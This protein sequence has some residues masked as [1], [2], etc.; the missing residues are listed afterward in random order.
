MFGSVGRSSRPRHGGF[1]LIELMITVAVIS[2]L[3]AVAYPSYR[4]SVAKGKRAQ[5]VASL[6][7]G[8]QWMERFYA[9][10]YRYDQ[11]TAAVAVTD[12]SLFRSRFTQAPP[13]P[14]AAAYTVAID[15]AT[16]TQTAFTIVAT[17]T[18]SMAGD[19]CGDFTI[20]QLGVKSVKNYGSNFA[21]VNAALAY[22]WK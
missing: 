4:E 8:S 14:D 18:G 12:N 10:N 20:N 22:C 15:T 17:R 6:Q 7:S 16:L 11:N 19:K 3:A 13:P 2:I 9:E 21:D 1:T 5:A